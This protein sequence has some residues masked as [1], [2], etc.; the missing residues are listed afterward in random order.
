[1]KGGGGGNK[2][3]SLCVIK[4]RLLDNFPKDGPADLQNQAELTFI[5]YFLLLNI[6][7]TW[8]LLRLKNLELL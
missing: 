3:V 8:I 2:N 7:F 1:M 4:Q 6:S 5:H